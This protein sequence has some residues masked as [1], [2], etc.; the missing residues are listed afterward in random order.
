MN[1]KL[2]RDAVTSRV[3]R[4][5][6]IGQKHSPTL[7]FAG[8]VVGIVGTVVLASRATLKLDEVLTEHER[9]META[10]SLQHRDYHE[11]DRRKDKAYVTARTMVKVSKLYAPAVALGTV[12]ICALTGSH[13]ILT[14]RNVALTAAYS[15][16]DKGFREYRERVVAEFGD[17]KD[18]EFRF[19]PFEERQ[20]IAES[21]EGPVV[22]TVKQPT[23]DGL[24]IYARFFDESCRAWSR[25]PMINQFYV[26]CQ[27]NYANDKLRSK[28]HLFLNEVYDMLGIPRTK[29]GAVVGWLCDGDGDGFVD[30][31]IFEGDTHSAT[32]FVNGEE[33]SIL[34]DFNVDGVIFDK[35]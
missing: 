35:I 24:S 3:G 8:G 9:D 2:I 16:L 1:V 15:A 33:R 22:K 19:G 28:G 23:A 26:Q 34:L 13:V 29:E 20:Y 32:R 18:K 6:L 7:L 21:K 10:S 17:E 4:Q 30:F 31:G 12:S 11:L 25:E 14:R 5:I 27:Q